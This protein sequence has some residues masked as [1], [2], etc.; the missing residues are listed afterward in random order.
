MEK[1]ISYEQEIPNADEFLKLRDDWRAQMR[2]ANELR[3][4]AIGLTILSNKFNYSYQW[5]WCGVPIIRHPDDMALQQEI[6]WSIKPTHVV[7]TGVARGGSLVLSA[8]LMEMCGAHSQVLGLDNQIMPHAK[9]SLEPWTIT[10]K[11]VLLECDSASEIAVTRVQNF[12]NGVLHPV[13]LVLDSNHSHAHV[14]NEL[15]A[16]APLLPIGSI[17]MVADTI[18]EEM[19]K[20]YYPNR[21]WGTGNNPSSAIREFLERNKNYKID[22]RWA[23]RSLMGECRDGILIRVTN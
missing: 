4:K 22:S 2:T 12:L 9:A 3:E 23:R 21:P 16:L 11:I 15:N 20:D 18:I 8:M 19:P 10:G 5:E 6:M 1:S 17:I 7:E 13:L 14:L